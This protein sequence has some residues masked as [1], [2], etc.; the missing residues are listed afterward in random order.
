MF[1]NVKCFDVVF[2]MLDFVACL[3]LSGVDGS[4][5]CEYFIDRFMAVAESSYVLMGAFE[6]CNVFRCKARPIPREVRTFS[7]VSKKDENLPVLECTLTV[8]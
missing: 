7:V 6:I 8:N 3:P 4:E 2:Q 1:T 5:K